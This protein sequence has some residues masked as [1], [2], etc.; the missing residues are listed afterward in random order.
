MAEVR[1]TIAL[2]VERQEWCCL[3]VDC[4]W[5][6]PSPTASVLDDFY[7]WHAEVSAI[8]RINYKSHLEKVLT[9]ALAEHDAAHFPGVLRP[10]ERL[11]M[12]RGRA[13]VVMDILIENGRISREEEL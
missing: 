2:D 4:A 3:V 7:K 9:E 11:M 8:A 10:V 5:K 13:H 6:T 1:H 12:A